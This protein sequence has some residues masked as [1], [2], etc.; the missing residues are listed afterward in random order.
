MRR[1]AVTRGTETASIDTFGCHAL[2]VSAVDKYA[3]VVTVILP[4]SALSTEIQ[5]VHLGCG[6][7][8]D[9]LGQNYDCRMSATSFA[10]RNAYSN[11]VN[12]VSE[13]TWTVYGLL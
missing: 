13:T 9:G 10:G 12:H 4:A 8:S 7:Q 11:L 2:L 5:T 6:Y 1:L 3:G